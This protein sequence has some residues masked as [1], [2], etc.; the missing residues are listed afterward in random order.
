[1]C[2]YRV[3]QVNGFKVFP[4]PVQNPGKVNEFM[5]AQKGLV[6]VLCVDADSKV[7]SCTCSSVYN[8]LNAPFTVHNT[9]VL[10]VS[11]LVLG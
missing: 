6:D 4:D 3:F 2:M 11:E 7:K 1:M 5:T 8:P 9:D 10:G